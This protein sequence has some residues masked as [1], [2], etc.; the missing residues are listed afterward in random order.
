MSELE[1]NAAITN[2]EKEK[3]LD[4]DKELQSHI[5][6]LHRELQTRTEA[7]KN[8][9]EHTRKTVEE[10]DGAIAALTEKNQSL[11]EDLEKSQQ[12]N[13]KLLSDKDVLQEEV[14]RCKKVVEDLHCQLLERED[15]VASLLEKIKELES[16]CRVVGNET[17][18]RVR[19]HCPFSYKTVFTCTLKQQSNDHTQRLPARIFGFFFQYTTD[20]LQ[21]VQNYSIGFT[22]TLNPRH[23]QYH[24]S[25]LIS[26]VLISFECICVQIFEKYCIV[27]RSLHK[28]ISLRQLFFHMIRANVHSTMRSV[29]FKR[30][31][32]RTVCSYI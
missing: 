26:I 30:N 12:A 2:E 4:E 19:G 28:Q 10:K 16:N 8:A 13:E 14:V 27:T 1:A 25:Q 21:T 18:M 11:H 3:R 24:K 15:C 22:T 20:C 17:G 23:S 6:C 5:E 9:D 7:M 29:L 31:L 32:K